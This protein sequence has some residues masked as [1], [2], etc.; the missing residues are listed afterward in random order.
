MP[1]SWEER[2]RTIDTYQEDGSAMA[3]LESWKFSF[4]L[5]NDKFFGGGFNAYTPENYAHYNPDS[6]LPQAAHSIYFS[7]LAEHGYVGLAIF[8]L[9]WFLAFR[10][11]GRVRRKTRDVPQARWAFRW[12]TCARW[13]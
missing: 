1:A 4:N 9:I 11:I 2:M 12:R 3:R 8:L 7:V 6:K 5:A 13:L 10:L